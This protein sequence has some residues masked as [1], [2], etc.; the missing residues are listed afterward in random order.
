MR[1]PARRSRSRSAALTALGTK[2]KIGKREYS[3]YYYATYNKAY[4]FYSI[5]AYHE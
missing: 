4:E 5:Y 1:T 2:A 3:E